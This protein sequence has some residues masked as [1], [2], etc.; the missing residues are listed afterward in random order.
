MHER[1]GVNGQHYAI[2][3]HLRLPDNWNGRFFF[4]GGGG[5]NGEIGDALGRVS[6]GPGK[7]VFAP[8]IARGYAVVS[9][10]S[11]HDNRLNS[12]PARGG[13]T[14]FG[15]DPEARADYGHASLAPVAR[16]AKAIITAYYHAPIKHAYFVGCSKG[17]EEGM[18]IAQQHPD[19][20]D[21]IVAAAPGFA[22]PR[23]AVEEAFQVQVL[24]K[25]IGPAAD[26]K[27]AFAAFH[28]AYS[29]AMLAQVAKAVA[30]ACDGLD[31]VKDGMIANVDAC[32]TA[33]VRPHLQPLLC[34]A[35]P[36][37]ACLRPEQLA[38]LMTLMGGAHWADGSPVYAPWA[39]DV[40]IAAPG[41]RIWKMGSSDGHVPALNIVLGGAS[42]YSVFTVPPVPVAMDPQTV[43]NA[44]MAFDI[45]KDGRRIYAT[46]GGFTRSGWQDSSA[47]A[48]DLSAF[49]ARGGRLIVPHGMSDPVFSAKD[50]IAWWT[51]V[52]AQAHGHAAEFARVFAV[53]GMNHCGGGPAT[54]QFDA[55]AS[56]VDWVEKAQAPQ[57]IIAKAGAQ[58]PFPGR[59]RP[60][61][62]YPAY[63]RY[64]GTGPVESAD[65]F[66]CAMPDQKH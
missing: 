66:A 19:L 12:D 26:G 56:L 34:S 27:V 10:D 62:A 60:L 47:H 25:L 15:F 2:R 18:V 65:S 52:N 29:D 58:T 44:Q 35:N 33:T 49:A 13:A 38:A 32:T 11:G 4:Q 51:A 1:I 39:W 20:F 64:N 40:G 8:A 45:A 46:G 59:S 63:A 28:G 3:F 43:L 41:W 54:D 57:R 30:D 36:G 7:M 23:A 24:A 61:C 48:T 50:T 21:G 22:L 42:L 14:A 16:A 37:D 53:P 31:G 5:S 55:F 9:Q 17:G 6:S